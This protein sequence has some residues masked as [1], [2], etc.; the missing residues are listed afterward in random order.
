M[1]G[2][3]EEEEEYLILGEHFNARTGNKEGLGIGERKEEKIK[4]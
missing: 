3:K 1:E 4:G 2:I